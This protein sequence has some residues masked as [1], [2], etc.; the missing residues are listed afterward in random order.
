MTRAPYAKNAYISPRTRDQIVDD[1]KAEMI[2]S[3]ELGYEIKAPKLTAKINAYYT[4]INDQTKVR[5]FYHDDE[6]SFVNYTLTGIDE[7]HRGIELSAL[8]KLTS[9]LSVKGVASIGEYYY[10]DRPV[11]TISQD[12]NAEVLTDRTVYMKNF[13][14]NGTP[15]KA[16]SLALSYN[17]P[18]YW[19]VNLSFNYFDDIFLDF[20][21]ERRTQEAVDGIDKNENPEL[22]YS[23]INQEQLDSDY[24]INFF[25]GKSWKIDDY[26]IYLHL[27]INNIL[28]NTNFK[29][30]GYEQLR[31][32]YYDR[33]INTYP[34]R[35]YYAYGLNYYINLSI[36][37]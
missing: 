16:Y 25:G 7:V 10:D 33:D 19:F 13:R 35:Y 15:Q 9:S 29:T 24:I 14:I 2:Y 11:A 17:S 5:S 8:Y 31:F 21:P 34:A 23:I 28:N 20:N 1:L 36:R 4:D 30:G 27:G 3:A 12:N 32:D 26:Y 22:W 37:I 18:N 6:A